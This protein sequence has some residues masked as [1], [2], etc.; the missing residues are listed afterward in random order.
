MS[1]FTVMVIGDNVAEQLQPYHEYEC[2]G[3]D[4]QYVVDVDVTDQL[5]AVLAEETEAVRLDDG[6]VKSRYDDQ[7]YTKISDNE[8][9][10]KL[11][12]KEF[13][14]PTGAQIVKMTRNQLREF[15]GE[16]VEEFAKE[17]GNWFERDG[18]YYNHTNQNAKWDWW[19][20]GGRW[21]GFFK[22]K[23]GATGVVGEPGLMTKPASERTADAALKSAIDF[24]GMRHK[25]EEKATKRWRQ[26]RQITPET[27][28]S[29][30]SIRNRVSDIA[31]A[32]DTYWEQPAI[33]A[34]R[35]P[36]H[37]RDF[38]DIDD[39]LAGSLED[40][41]AAARDA[42]CVPYALVRDSQ[43][44]ARGDMGWWGISSN[45]QNRGDWNRKVN[46]LLDSL[47]DDTLLT[48]V[49]CHI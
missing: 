44:Y 9:D 22:L 46:E 5:N 32:R 41:V 12:R 29:W 39:N 38:F 4:D 13:E 34:L 20:V 17:Y 43:W 18:R 30:D 24:D 10:R 7:F 36:P 3:I 16:S 2:T 47:P 49:D 27:W 6:T 1:H 23:S 35:A 31:L 25:A 42:A 37:G 26:V 15:E 48:I 28:E 45:E 33:K 40:Y 8:I 11:D 21:T 14:L 19:V